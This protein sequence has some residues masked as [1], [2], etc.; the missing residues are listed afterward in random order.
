MS[1][2]TLL[3][4]FGHIVF[5]FTRGVAEHYNPDEPEFTPELFDYN[6]L[7]STGREWNFFPVD[8]MIYQEYSERQDTTLDYL[9]ASGFRVRINDACLPNENQE[10]Q[11]SQPLV[12][13]DIAM[14]WKRLRP[15]VLATVCKSLYIG[16]SISI[17]AATTTGVL[18]SLLT[19]VGYQTLF[20]CEYRPGESIP[21]EIQWIRTSSTLIAIFLLY[22]WILMNMLFFFRPYQLSGVKRKCASVAFFLFCLD[23]LYRLAFQIFQIS[24]SKL[25]KLQTLPCNA[26]FY[27]SGIWQVYLIV[28]HL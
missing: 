19:Y 10:I 5:S 21:V 6:A 16:A 9:A 14:A 17:L 24:H 11:E 13:A 27:I 2:R 18:Y 25:S 8:E 7:E 26:I 1:S 3:E 28:N 20:N 12:E 15:S 22:M 23:A 4:M